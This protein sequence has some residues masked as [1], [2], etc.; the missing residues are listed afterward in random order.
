MGGEHPSVAG[1]YNNIG[2]TWKNK[3]EYVKALEFYENA[4]HIEI[5]TLGQEHPDVAISYFNIGNCNFELKYY[6]EAIDF[7]KKG[8]SILNKGGFPFQIGKCYEVL[9]KKGLALDYFIQ[10]AE[11]R[12]DDPEFGLDNERT[13]DSI[14]NT[15]R[16]AKEIGKE[17]ELPEWMKEIN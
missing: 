11:I 7:Y 1:S 14:T 6:A 9:D 8:F 13:K 17:N 10:S 3:G 16:L 15:K 4:L 5:K 12:K 2:L